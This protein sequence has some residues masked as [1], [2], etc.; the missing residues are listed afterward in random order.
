MAD[1]S[2]VEVTDITFEQQVEK[3]KLPVAVMFYSP[4]CSFCRMMEPSFAQYAAEYREKVA[5]VR[6]NVMAN[7]FTGDRFGIRS[8]P[9]FAF[10]C[11]GKPVETMVGAVYPAL[12]KKR[13]DEVLIHGKECALSSTAIDYEITGYG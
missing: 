9:T 2:V 3:A 10:F 7:L 1:T 12:L 4:T 5:F 13:I 6:V 8:T 11:G